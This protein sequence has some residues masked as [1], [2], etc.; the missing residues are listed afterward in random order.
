M[1]TKPCTQIKLGETFDWLTSNDG[2]FLICNEI[3][4]FFFYS[5]GKHTTLLMPSISLFE[6]KINSA[7]FV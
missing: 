6:A 3:C 2:Y 4:D 5:T 1:V 7:H